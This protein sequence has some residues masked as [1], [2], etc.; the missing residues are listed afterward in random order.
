MNPHRSEPG[1]PNTPL[2]RWP[3]PS[4]VLHWLGAALILGLGIVGFLMTDLPETSSARLDLSRLHTVGG[5]LLMLLTATRLVV[6]W[7]GPRVAPLAV[8]ALHRR[9]IG[10]TH[11]LMYVA[12]FGLGLS[13]FL[14]GAQSAWPDYLMEQLAEVPVLGDL[15]ARGIHE[16]LVFALIVLIVLHVGGIVL[17][18]LILGPRASRARTALTE[19]SDAT[20][21]RRGRVARR[22]M[23][24]LK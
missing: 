3:R 15:A 9:G 11:S 17:H 10:V 5:L 2:E 4:V 16:A 22:M 21:F 1:S 20:G 7:R 18:E 23:P 14:M 12:T 8:P 24:W 13:G 6:R 19:A